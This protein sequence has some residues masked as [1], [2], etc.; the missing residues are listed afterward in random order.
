M[1][2]AFKQWGLV[3]GLLSQAPWVSADDCAPLNID[4]WTQASF[5]LSGDRLVVNNRPL[6]LI[7]VQAP[8]QPDKTQFDS[9]GQPLA[10]QAQTQLNQLIANHDLSVGIEYDQAKVDDF[11]TAQAHVY[12]KEADGTIVSLQKKLLQTGFVLAKTQT[13]NLNHQACYYQAERQARQKQ[14]GLWQLARSQ[15]QLRFPIAPSS[16]ITT[17]NEGYHIYRGEIVSVQRSDKNYMLNMDTTGVR[18]RRKHWDQ[19]DYAQ[20]QALKGQV[21]EARGFGFLYNGAMY[22]KVYAPFAIDQL[23][24]VYKD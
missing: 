10:K 22:V 18:I 7:G 11:G 12:V 20:L 19:F 6:R 1:K 13:P 5:A 16:E 2:L 24:P 17:D 21:V 14:R 8:K 3:L 15:P 9:Q 23:N 4:G